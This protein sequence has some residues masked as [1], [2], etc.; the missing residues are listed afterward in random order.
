[1]KRWDSE[2]ERR[3]KVAHGPWEASLRS[4]MQKASPGLL[5][6]EE[7]AM[8]LSKIGEQ[9]YSSRQETE[10]KTGPG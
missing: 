6:E 2:G 3:V 9:I 1:M 4:S 10:N 8:Y 7:Q 5:E